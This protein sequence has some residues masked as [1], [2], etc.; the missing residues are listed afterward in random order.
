MIADN[1]KEAGWRCGCI[2]STDHEGRQFWVVAVERED[3]G[4]FIVHADEK[5]NAFVEL[6]RQVLTMTFYLESIH[7]DSCR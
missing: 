4:R 5:L 6:E 1:L 3:A 2:S 7:S